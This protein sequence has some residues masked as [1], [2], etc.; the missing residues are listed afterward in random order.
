MSYN[1]CFIFARLVHY[2]IAILVFNI[3]V[4]ILLLFYFCSNLVTS[5]ME[6]MLFLSL[7]M[8]IFAKDKISVLL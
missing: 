1:Y 7:I 4:L 8:T 5:E 2:F 3:P 6:V